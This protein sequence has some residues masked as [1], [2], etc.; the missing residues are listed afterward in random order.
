[1][2][3]YEKLLLILFILLLLF[4]SIV[5]TPKGMTRSVLVLGL[6]T[7]RN[8]RPLL[9]DFGLRGN[10]VDRDENQLLWLDSLYDVVQVL[11]DIQEHIIL[12]FR[13]RLMH[14]FSTSDRQPARPRS[15]MPQ[16][17]RSDGCV[18]L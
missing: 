10:T 18:A 2:R 12:V 11:A 13:R 16:L 7:G 1:M 14:R 15:T 4:S 8:L 9:I 3:F 5:T 17:T 6:Q